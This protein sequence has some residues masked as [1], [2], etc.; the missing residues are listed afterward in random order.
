ML[1]AIEISIDKL[2]TNACKLSDKVE[3]SAV[4]NLIHGDV[5]KVMLLVSV[6]QL[7]S[8]I[9]SIKNQYNEGTGVHQESAK[10]VDNGYPDW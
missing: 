8:I 7:S 4:Q 1:E 3:H 10:I 6:R 9:H 5:D 2:I